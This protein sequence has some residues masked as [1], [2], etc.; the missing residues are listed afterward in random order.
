MRDCRPSAT[1]FDVSHDLTWGGVRPAATAS[2]YCKA[3]PY[4]VCGVLIELLTFGRAL[5]IARIE[6]RA[7]Y[8]HCPRL[9]DLLPCR[10]ALVS[11]I[12]IKITSTVNSIRTCITRLRTWW[13][14]PLMPSTV[15]RTRS[16]EMLPNTIEH[17]TSPC[18]HVRAKCVRANKTRSYRRSRQKK[19]YDSPWSMTTW[20]EMCYNQPRRQGRSNTKSMYKNRSWR[21]ARA[22]SQ[23]SFHVSLSGAII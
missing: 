23:L 11:T 15:Q 18:N 16:E 5:I 10:A 1:A 21:L 6:R 9:L 4:A 12:T 8:T 14:W 3:E 13:W 22:V 20:P 19:R 2:S 17:H 7:V